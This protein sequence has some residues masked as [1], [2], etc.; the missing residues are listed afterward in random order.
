MARN[1]TTKVFRERAVSMVIAGKSEQQVA[2]ELG[3]EVHKIRR[4]YNNA[5]NA[6]AEKKPE[7]FDVKVQKVE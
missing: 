4:W 3:I 6:T 5:M 2:T 7:L 1:M